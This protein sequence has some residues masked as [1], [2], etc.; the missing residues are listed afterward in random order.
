MQ[1]GEREAGID[2]RLLHRRLRRVVRKGEHGM[3]DGRED[4]PLYPRVDCLRDQSLPD[5]CLIGKVDRSDVENG[6]R[7]G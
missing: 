3:D 6:F 1:N 2:D 5:R 7:A 4:E